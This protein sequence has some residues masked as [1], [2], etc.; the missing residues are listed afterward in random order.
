L[1]SEVIAYFFTNRATKIGDGGGVEHEQIVVHTPSLKSIKTWLRRQINAGKLI[2]SKVYVA[3][4]FA[5][6]K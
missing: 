4:Y 6:A 2:D 3:L 1:S 5:T